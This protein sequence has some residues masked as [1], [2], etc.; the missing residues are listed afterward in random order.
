MNTIENTIVQTSFINN[1]GETMT[2]VMDKDY[3]A[4]FRHTD[5]NDKFENFK[6]LSVPNFYIFKYVIDANERKVLSTFCE[7]CKAIAEA[8]GTKFV[9]LQL[10]LS[11]A[12]TSKS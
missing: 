12:F 5:C 8:T 10:D 1:Y 2:L 9:D 11:K 7:L 6:D 4:W 3:N